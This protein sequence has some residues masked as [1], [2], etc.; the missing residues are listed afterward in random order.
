L[1]TTTPTDDTAP[2]APP[3]PLPDSPFASALKALEWEK[4]VR[5]LA[6]RSSSNPGRELCLAAAP[7]TDLDLIRT[8]L[9]E[10]RDGRRMLAEDGPLPL[11]GLDEIDPSVARAGKGT[12]LSPQELL[13]VGG[14]ARAAERTRR[15]FLDRKGKYPRLSHYANRLPLLKDLWDEIDWK[16]DP[17]GNVPDRAS[18]ALGPLRKRMAHVKERLHETAEG[19]LTSA[20][21]QR[22]VQD[23]FVTVRSGRLV[24]PFK[25]AAK[26]MFPG[27]V[28]DTSQTGQ[29]VFLE[30][31]ELVHLNNDAKM[32]ELEVEREVARI[33]SE[34]SAR[35]AHRGPDL[36]FAKELLSL[37]DLAQ[38]RA[39]LAEE[40]A[41]AEPAV[42]DSGT[43]RLLSARHPLMV[44]GRKKVVPNDLVLGRPYLCLI[45]TG[46]NAGGKTVAL[47]TLGL[48]TLMAM[49]GLSIP[50]SPDSHV[51]AFRKVFAAVGDEQSVEQD[52]STFSAHMRR[53]HGILR[54]AGRGSLVLL[55]EVVSGTDPR[56]GA[57]L[58]RAF[59]EALADR[60]VR[61]VATTHF[62][63]LK[64]IAFEDGRFENG[65]MEFDEERLLP[66]YRLRTGIPGKSMAMEIA[67]SLAFPEEVL[68][69]AS[70]FLTEEG[71]RLSAV[72]SGL[73]EERKRL[74]VEA[75][76]L[77]AARR[78]A[79]KERGRLAEERERVR[80][81]EERRL[82]EG[83]RKI[84]EEI[85]K[86]EA[87]L[88]KVT[89]ELR[90]ERK[91]E[92]VRKA[93][94]VMRDWREK[95]RAEGDDP[96]VRAAVSR[97]APWEPGTALSPGRKVFLATLKKDGEVAA[98]AAG[99]A[100]EAEVLAGGLRLR[101]PREQIRLYPPPGR[102]EGRGGGAAA[103]K[104]GSEGLRRVRGQAP[105][106][107]GGA[108]PEE[109][110]YLQTE[111]NTLDLRGMYVDDALPELDAFLDR[112]AVSQRPYVIVVHGHGTGAMK[113]G[114]RR[115]L[116][117]APHAKRFFPAP[118]NRGG[119]G[120]TV[121]LLD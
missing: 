55:D 23:A 87:E 14:T 7:S 99:D 89:E 39:L 49:A 41:S 31:E 8:R 57:A 32:A 59:L 25:A 90:K 2:A 64:A 36:L 35:V 42:D 26:G 88:L 96:A 60:G 1:D 66:A 111:E 112:A 40:T 73:E 43:V 63:E 83:R 44:L 93:Q 78:D 82:A 85:R 65:S 54:D 53:L 102:D 10:N 12:S 106:P 45:L 71:M 47:K 21:Y 37:L 4:V 118:G 91:I 97:T 58:A 52:L 22:H 48:L 62:E 9:E 70:S 46:P 77:A 107:S 119:D 67:R 34:L 94:V 92:T 121:V 68:V 81:E 100:R 116:K 120:A 86:A 18:A 30:P 24:I 110:L 113:N 20:R 74:K 51:C 16:I 38:A 76:A 95:T 117:G 98:A 114:V 56:E 6:A 101:L 15:F 28:H 5:A 105:F 11:D 80:S 84:R 103:G 72:L 69:R 109:E 61:T 3:P 108:S 13:A 75:E 50:A 17:S 29:T 27:I 104:R 115:H 33:L 19:M 79:E